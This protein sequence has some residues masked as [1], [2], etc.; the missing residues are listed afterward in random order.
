MSDTDETPQETPQATPAPVEPTSPPEPK[1][2]QT[3][4][5]SYDPNGDGY[6]RTNPNTSDV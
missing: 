2:S 6:I 4:R 1:V 5:V 3:E